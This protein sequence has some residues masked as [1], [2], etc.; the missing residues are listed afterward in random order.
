[1]AK[2]ICQP[3]SQVVQRKFFE[4]FENRGCKMENDVVI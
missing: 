4:K 3:K 2:M 1:M